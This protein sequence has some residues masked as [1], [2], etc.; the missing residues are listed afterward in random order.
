[1]L[2][3]VNT[4]IRGPAPA[5]M[6]EV[7]V[8]RKRELDALRAW[9]D[10]ARAGDGAGRC[11]LCVGEPGIGKTRLAQEL[12]GFALAGGTAVAWGRCPEGEGGPSFWP[13]RQVLRSLGIAPDRVF[14]GDVESPEERF[15]VFD[16]VTEAVRGAA[17]KSG[18]LV[19]LD[20][21]HGADEPSLLL[22][23]HLADQVTQ[24]RLLVVAA[25]RDV[26]LAPGS[27]LRRVLPELLR[28]PVVERLD[29]RGFG[30]EVGKRGAEVCRN[31][32]LS[33]SA[34]DRFGWAKVVADVVVGEDIQRDVCVSSVPHFLVEV[35][36]EL[37]VGRLG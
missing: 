36:Y 27:A 31:L 23:R 35:S 29:L 6:G 1:M 30:H 10:A 24:A 28:S 9:L 7:F 12:A 22:L 3:G 37:L 32:R 18:L 34:G 25:L 26:G 2:G 16:D 20:D 21:I 15:R 17:D 19:V 14:A 4:P 5:V 8:G 11:V 13:W 33:R